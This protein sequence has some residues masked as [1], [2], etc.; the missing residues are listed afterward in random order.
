MKMSINFRRE[1]AIAGVQLGQ[2]VFYDGGDGRHYEAS[3][4]DRELDEFITGSQIAVDI[5]DGDFSGSRLFV[6]QLF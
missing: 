1:I 4:A 5:D 3:L 2:I 6:I